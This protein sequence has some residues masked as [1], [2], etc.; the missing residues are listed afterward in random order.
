M[1]QQINPVP[2]RDVVLDLDDKINY[3]VF[4]SG[5]NISV[6]RYP[7]NS[8]T[9][10]QHVYN[11]Q[12]PSTSTV[13]SRNLVWGATFTITVTGSVAP[14]VKLVNFEPLNTEIILGAAGTA[15]V[16]VQAGDC[17]APFP[18]NMLCSN[19]S[20][21]INNTTVSAQVNNILD[22]LL[23][24]VDRKEFQRWNGTTPTQLDKFGDYT[25]ALPLYVAQAGTAS[26]TSPVTQYPND[27]PTFN[28]PFN[29]FNNA[30][31]NNDEVP[32]NSFI[33]N[34]ITGNDPGAG[35]STGDL[36]ARTVAINV[37]VREP[38]FVSPF[39]FGESGEQAGLSGLTQILVTCQMDSVAKRAL[40]WVK[41]ADNVILNKA[42]Q[43]VAYDQ[44]NCY[45]ECMYYTPKPSD[46]IPATIV[47]PL[48]TY[49]LYQIPAGSNVG[50][51]SSASLTSN[52]IMLN[53]YPDKVF[54]WIDNYAKWGQYGNTVSDSYLT[55]DSINITL[56][57]QSGILTTF[58][59]EQL[60]RAGMKS[61][62]KMTWAEFSGAQRGVAQAG[63][64]YGP[65]NVPTCAGPLM[66]NFGDVIN[67][68]QDYYAP[69]SLSTCQFQIQNV[70]FTNTQSQTLQPQLN[71][72]V[73]QS[74]ILSTSNGASSAY[75]SGVLSKE[76]VL[77][78]AAQPAMNVHHLERY[79]GSG[80][81]GSLK[82]IATSVLPMAKKALGAF[83]DNKYAKA[84]K[85]AL[86]ALGYGK[87]LK[88]KLM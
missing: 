58:S 66:L 33:I 70:S 77:G 55:I 25:N 86:D 61:G 48:A 19:A 18:L 80:L 37:T 87:R 81:M 23:R 34:S 28:S 47:T 88:S 67:I 46:L 73:M 14:G 83:E 26:G 41:A 69:G 63:G 42:V 7:A 85:D 35:T 27:W 76:A 65:Q 6:Q 60:F 71:I 12:I 78:A 50:A 31:C 64:I 44:A 38:L 20:V 57:N 49:T 22:P 15:P 75:T 59:K 8:A 16:L 21:Q 56:N 9:S 74:G 4:R 24:A 32:R 1:S 39:L 43:S 53:S 13:L 84:G 82:S 11:V 54:V 52:S 17:L 30:N 51:G 36:E 62:S 45:I 40:R 10:S 79:V 5:Q 3:A 2:V 68:P 29:N 72:L